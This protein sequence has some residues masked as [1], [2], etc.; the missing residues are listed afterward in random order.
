MNLPFK[1]MTVPIVTKKNINCP[2]TNKKTHKKKDI[3]VTDWR[4]LV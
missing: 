3:I 4:V 2:I 1:R